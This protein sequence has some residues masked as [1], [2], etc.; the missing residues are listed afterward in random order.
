MVSAPT[1]DRNTPPRLASFDVSVIGTRRPDLSPDVAFL[2]PLLPHPERF[3]T[4]ALDAGRSM[5]RPVFEALACDNPY[6]AVHF[7]EIHFNPMV[8]KALAADL[9]L[10]RVVGLSGRVTAELMRLTRAYIAERRAS[11]RMVP[12]EVWRLTAEAWSAA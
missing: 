11:G 1:L 6:P 2:L 7:H 8:M 3:L 5:T 10:D 4:S 9:S 12:T